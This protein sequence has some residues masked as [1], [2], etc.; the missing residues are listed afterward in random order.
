MTLKAN[1]TV[2]IAASIT[3]AL[4]LEALA[5]SLN[6]SWSVALADGTGAGQATRMWSDVRNLAS[7]TSESLD[8]SGALVDAFGVSVTLTKIKMLIIAA[9]PLNTTVLTAGNVTNG[10]IA[11]FLAA[12]GGIIIRPGGLFVAAAPD[13]TGFGVTDATADLLKIANAAGAAA[14]YS[15]AV[16]GI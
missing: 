5:S 10:I 1:L 15:I 8:L 2:S 13:V 3:G 12:T 14:N 9:D 4:D 7:N 11:P 6:Q 16:I